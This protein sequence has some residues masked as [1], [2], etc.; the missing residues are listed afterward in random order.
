MKIQGQVLKLYGSV[1]WVHGMTIASE[2]ATV[3]GFWRIEGL[4][5]RHSRHKKGPKFKCSSR[6]ARDGGGVWRHV[7]TRNVTKAERNLEWP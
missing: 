4:G 7:M 1:I 3:A 5:S 2:A 6:G